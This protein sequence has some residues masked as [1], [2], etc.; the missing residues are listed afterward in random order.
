MTLGLH[1]H[2]LVIDL[3]GLTPSSSRSSSKPSLPLLHIPAAPYRAASYP[4]TS[5]ISLSPCRPLRSHLPSSPTKLLRGILPLLLRTP[6]G[7]TVLYPTPPGRPRPTAA[8]RLPPPGPTRPQ[9]SASERP[10]RRP[11][12]GVTP[13]SPR[14][15]ADLQPL[16]S[17][18]SSRLGPES[19][20]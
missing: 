8:A 6:P 17:P 13:R 16:T 4:I 7:T 18:H 12:E 14:C 15:T 9:A 5:T 2:P 20:H 19:Y 11:G 1:N 10:P 3:Q